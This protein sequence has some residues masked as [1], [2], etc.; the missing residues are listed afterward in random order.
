MAQEWYAP[1]QLYPV[2][3]H[4]GYLQGFVNIVGGQQ[5]DYPP[6]L[7]QGKL[8]LMVVPGGKSIEF[9]TDPIPESDDDRVTFV[10][11]ASLPKTG[12]QQ[13]ARFDFYINGG[14]SQPG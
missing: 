5:L 7:Q 6:I 13:R 11:Q 9:E 14:V 10:W 1:D 12:S 8:A 4:H 2:E 3:G